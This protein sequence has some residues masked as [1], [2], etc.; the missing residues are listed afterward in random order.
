MSPDEIVLGLLAVRPQHGYAL[1][2]AFR[3][4]SQ[5]GA[6]WQL[7]TSQLYVVLKRLRVAGLVEG[8]KQESSDAPARIEYALTTDGQM[9]LAAWM[10]DAPASDPATVRVDFLSRLYIAQMLDV[11]TSAIIQRQ[12]VACH[13]RRETLL[14]QRSSF[15]AGVEWLALEYDIAQMNAVLDW[16]DHLELAASDDDGEDG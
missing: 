5:L 15:R 3:D 13:E 6:V 1:I 14:E 8:R 16:I 11:P 9:H 2:E 10:T 12:R 7:S 4:A